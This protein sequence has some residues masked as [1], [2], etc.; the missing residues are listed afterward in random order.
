MVLVLVNDSD[1]RRITV[2]VLFKAIGNAPILKQKFYKITAANRFQAVIQFLR[3][4]LGYK[5]GDPLVRALPL[6]YLVLNA[7]SFDGWCSSLIST[8]RSRLRRM[9]RLSTCIR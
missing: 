4:E 8:M 1:R 2:V 3:R 9:T 5:P 6:L 7:D